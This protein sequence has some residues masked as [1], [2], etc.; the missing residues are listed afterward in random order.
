MRFSVRLLHELFHVIIKN[1]KR[2]DW[3]SLIRTISNSK[4]PPFFSIMSKNVPPWWQNNWHDLLKRGLYASCYPDFRHKLQ[5]LSAQKPKIAPNSLLSHPSEHQTATPHPS[6]ISHQ[7]CLTSSPQSSRVLTARCCVY[8]L[9]K[10]TQMQVQLHRRIRPGLQ[11][12]LQASAKLGLTCFRA[13]Y[14][15]MF[16]QAVPA[17]S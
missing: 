7:L 8:A 2:Q 4:Q 11:F 16:I 5:I 1:C 12:S 14:W 10:A 3:L 17:E 15:V 13:K 9:G 6:P